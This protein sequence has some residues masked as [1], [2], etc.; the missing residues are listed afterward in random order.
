MSVITL[1]L[2]K[3]TIHSA[4]SAT[5]NKPIITKAMYDEYSACAFNTTIH[6]VKETIEE[7]VY[8]KVKNMLQMENKLVM[9]DS[10]IKKF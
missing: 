8:E 7:P 5:P 1:F 2:V 4:T 10:I 3:A 6:L 9:N